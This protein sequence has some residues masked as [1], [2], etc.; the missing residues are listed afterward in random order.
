MFPD[1]WNMHRQ[2]WN[3]TEGLGGPKYRE[4]RSALGDTPYYAPLDLSDAALTLPG[5]PRH[6]ARGYVRMCSRYAAAALGLAVGV[7]C[8]EGP[9]SAPP[10]VRLVDRFEPSLVS[11]SPPAVELPPAAAWRFDGSTPS[12]AAFAD[13]G[14]VESGPGVVDLAVQ[15][16]RLVGRSTTETPLLRVER[17]EGLDQEDLPSRRRG[18]VAGVGRQCAARHDPT[19]GSGRPR[20]LPAQIAGSPFRLETPI[21]PGDELHT[22][23]LT[24]PTPVEATGIRHLIVV[25]TNEAEAEFEIES[26]RVVFRREQLAGIPSG[27][28]VAG[29]LVR[30]TRK[31][32]SPARLRRCRST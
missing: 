2:D 8:S 16:G 24:S 31:R 13:T 11:G 17:T 29:D 28:R 26:I 21:V 12:P 9:A 22:Y 3:L 5:R 14:G 23:T 32:W 7:A 15:D 1:S 30:C 6:M 27:G 4:K 18:A 25:P 10:A 20:A 19:R